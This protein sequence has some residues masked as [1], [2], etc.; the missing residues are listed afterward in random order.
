[1]SIGIYNK[2]SENQNLTNFFKLDGLDLELN[3]K[4]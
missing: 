3:N 1:M 4:L 2:N